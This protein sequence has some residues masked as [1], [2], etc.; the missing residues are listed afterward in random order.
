[1]YRFWAILLV[2]MTACGGGSGGA[3]DENERLEQSDQRRY[4]VTEDQVFT[5]ALSGTCD[6]YE[7]VQQPEHGEIQCDS[8]TWQY[9]VDKNYVGEDSFQYQPLNTVD[10]V[11]TVELTIK[12]DA[13]DPIIAF[14]M[15]GNEA[16]AVQQQEIACFA[17]T[18]V[19]SAELP[20]QQP[21]Q[22][23]INWLQ[24]C[25]LDSNGVACFEGGDRNPAVNVPELYNP[26]QLYSGGTY[27]C[28]LDDYG[29][30]CWGTLGAI[31]LPPANQIG[32]NNLNHFA[33]GE[34]HICYIDG[35]QVI[36]K[37]TYQFDINT[38]EEITT[39]V[40]NNP[41]FVASGSIN[42]CAIDANGVSCWGSFRDS[43]MTIDAATI[44]PQ[45]LINPTYVAVGNAHA[46]AI[47]N[48]EVYCWGIDRLERLDVPDHIV[49][50]RFLAIFDNRSCVVDDNGVIC[51]GAAYSQFGLDVPGNLYS[52]P[53]E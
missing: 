3:S 14:D 1:M 20:A 18:R 53:I 30:Q 21:L 43:V 46:C 24:S 13:V 7:V 40:L 50:P 28:A 12:R 34:R 31:E 10:D 16:C 11:V 9:L 19:T 17:Q 36:C 8:A 27:T 37:G 15:G 42:S 47:D 44:N 26:Y 29:L 45:Q 51:W 32:R 2:F 25:V 39:P 5:L 48:S 6:N 38:A 4:T 23:A 52:F 41:E 49:N 22:V 35:G 33:A